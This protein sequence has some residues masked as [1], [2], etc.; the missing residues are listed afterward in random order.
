MVQNVSFFLR[1]V[2][3]HVSYLLNFLWRSG[4]TWGLRNRIWSEKN[5]IFTIY[6]SIPPP[7]LVIGPIYVIKE[8]FNVMIFEE[9]KE[10]KGRNMILLSFKCFIINW[11]IRLTSRGIFMY[12]HVS[13]TLKIR[14]KYTCKIK[15]ESN[16]SSLNILFM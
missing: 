5:V 14:I 4:S 15:H 13:M 10:S 11:H 2:T 1:N 9:T 16:V 8:Y 7:W 3:E 12:E 6:R